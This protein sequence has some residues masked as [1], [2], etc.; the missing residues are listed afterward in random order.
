MRS[1]LSTLSR[2]SAEHD[3]IKKNLI[4]ID[5]CFGI[6]SDG[7]RWK[8][9]YDYERIRAGFV[10]ALLL[11][12][13]DAVTEQP[14]AGLASDKW[15]AVDSHV[16]NAADSRAAVVNEIGFCLARQHWPHV[17]AIVLAVDP[18]V[19]QLEQM[20]KSANA[21]ETAVVDREIDRIIPSIAKC[22]PQGTKIVMRRLQLRFLLEETTLHAIGMANAASGG[23]PGPA[24]RAN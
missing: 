23:D 4:N 1:L 20:P 11:R 3:V 24:S 7:S 16:M 8:E 10:R 22:V 5:T 2:S 21:R 17:R 9:S 6:L 13:R 19:E 18:R 14:P 15:Y 12:N